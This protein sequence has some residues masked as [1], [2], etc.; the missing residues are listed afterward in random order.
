MRI[1]R[2]AVKRIHLVQGLQLAGGDVSHVSGPSGLVV[3]FKQRGQFSWFDSGSDSGIKS[4]HDFIG[5]DF[6]A[7]NLSRQSF[8]EDG[9]IN[10]CL[11]KSATV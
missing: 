1:C 11:C 10:N 5:R 7:P 4:L 3:C 2:S 9:S 6:V 8:S